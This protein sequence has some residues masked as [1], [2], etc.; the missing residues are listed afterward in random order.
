MGVF[1]G[2]GFR[3]LGFKVG[4]SKN[5]VCRF[6]GSLSNKDCGIFQS[7]LGSPYSGKIPAPQIHNSELRLAAASGEPGKSEVASGFIRVLG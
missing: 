2:L 5:W 3:G 1:K 7:I 4:V 6:G